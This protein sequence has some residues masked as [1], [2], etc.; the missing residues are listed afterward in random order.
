[1][2]P[3]EKTSWRRLAFACERPLHFPTCIGWL[4]HAE[5]R[6]SHAEGSLW[7]TAK[8]LYL[9]RLPEMQS[10]YNHQIFEH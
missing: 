1:M 8:F 10:V 4:S 9:M 2:P 3:V 7:I 6:L 5:G